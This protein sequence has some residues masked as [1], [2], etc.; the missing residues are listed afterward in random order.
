MGDSASAFNLPQLIISQI[1]DLFDTV[2]L[3]FL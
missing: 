1:T 2:D 3:F